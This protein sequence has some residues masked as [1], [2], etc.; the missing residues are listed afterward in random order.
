MPNWDN[1]HTR[2]VQAD[3]ADK[4]ESG[5]DDGYRFIGYP[6]PAFMSKPVMRLTAYERGFVF[7]WWLKEWL[8]QKKEIDK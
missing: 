5:I 3:T 4:Y 2:Q 1:A 7:G 6:L 8:T